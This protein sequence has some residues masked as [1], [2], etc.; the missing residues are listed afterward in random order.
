MIGFTGRKRNFVLIFLFVLL[1]LLVFGNVVIASE[2]GDHGGKVTDLIYRIINFTLLVI[3][4]VWVL[5]KASIKDFF[6]ARSEEIKK[7]FEELKRERE[8]TETRYKELEKNLKEFEIKKQEILD[9]FKT[10]GLA[11]KEKIIS[12]AKERADQIIAQA[13]VA[14]ERE[15][16]AAR[17]RLMEQVV[18][19]ASHKA[20]EIIEKDIK[21]SDQDHLV[22]EFIER[23]GKL[24]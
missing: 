4:L 14:I 13:D 23:V 24:N 10:E 3:I 9:Q 19:V 12:E 11:E 1:G 2:G 8:A 16:N 17:D 21:N 5:R 18:D 22:D 6:S 7:K 15:I 20:K